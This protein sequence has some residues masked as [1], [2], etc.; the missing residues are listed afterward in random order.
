MAE[1]H[2][3]TEVAERPVSTFTIP[4]RMDDEVPEVAEHPVSTFTIPDRMDE[5]PEVAEHPVSTFTIPDRMAEVAERPVSTFTIDTLY[6]VANIPLPSNSDDDLREPRAPYLATSSS[7]LVFSDSPRDSSYLNPTLNGSGLLLN[8]QKPETFAEDTIATS[9]KSKRRSLIRIAILLLALVLIIIAVVVPVYFTVIKPK[10]NVANPNTSGGS[11]G[12]NSGGGGGGTGG[13][14]Q[15][16]PGVS[17]AITGGDGSTI[18][19][20]DGS[21]FIYNNSFGGF[22]KCFPDFFFLPN[23]KLL[24]RGFDPC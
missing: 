14:T 22:C 7:P 2:E 15:P 6:A 16:A 20:T 19:A 21:T 24:R 3:V 17:N 18:H 13:G 23:W 10:S 9:P 1:V 8:A 11:P 5:V 12:P 4:V